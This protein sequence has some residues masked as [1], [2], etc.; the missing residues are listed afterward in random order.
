MVM[1]LFREHDLRTTERTGRCDKADNRTTMQHRSA[2]CFGC[3]IDGAAWK[4]VTVTS[5]RQLPPPIAD[6][7]ASPSGL[8]VLH[9]E[10]N[11]HYVPLQFELVAMASASCQLTKCPLRNKIENYHRIPWC[12]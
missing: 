2:P 6:D 9:C 3:P 7:L 8:L 11:S 5:L 4:Q 12:G 1:L 10:I